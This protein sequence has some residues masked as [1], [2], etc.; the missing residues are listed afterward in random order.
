MSRQG[1]TRRSRYP[2]WSGWVKEIRA[3]DPFC[4]DAFAGKANLHASTE[5]IETLR[6]VYERLRIE[7]SGR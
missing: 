3:L 4:S 2:S 6:Q 5:R 7:Q 1:R